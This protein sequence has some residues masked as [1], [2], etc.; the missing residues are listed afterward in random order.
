MCVE[1]D[2][3]GGKSLMIVI[4]SFRD[5]ICQIDLPFT[6][7]ILYK[8]D[9]DIGRDLLDDHWGSSSITRYFNIPNFDQ[10]QGNFVNRTSLNQ[11]CQKGGLIPYFLDHDLAR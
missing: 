8:V 7:I 10:A 6:L 11:I 9:I 3:R 2:I 5:G 4:D 1:V